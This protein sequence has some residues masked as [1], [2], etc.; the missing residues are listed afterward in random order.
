MLTIPLDEEHQLSLCLQE[1]EGGCLLSCGRTDNTWSDTQPVLWTLPAG[2]AHEIY[3]IYEDWLGGQNQSDSAP[4]LDWTHEQSF[5]QL[6]PGD[7]ILGTT[8]VVVPASGADF[9]YMIT[10]TRTGLTLE[11][12]LR[13]E[14]GTEYSQRVVGGDLY[15][16]ITN[17]PAG[18]YIPFVCNTGDYTQYPIYGDNSQD[19]NATGTL[20]FLLKTPPSSASHPASAQVDGT[21]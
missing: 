15:G 6:V 13:A 8:P 19:Y 7:E 1:V 14:D 11:F 2:T 5:D 10:Y 9:T 18:S 4:A 20:V 21:S 3:A 16:T 17:I 12:G